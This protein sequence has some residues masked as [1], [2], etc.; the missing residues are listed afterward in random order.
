VIGGTAQGFLGEYMAGGVLALLGIGVETHPAS[1]IGTGMC[2]GIIYIRGTVKEHQLGKEVGVAELDGNDRRILHGLIVEYCN[3]FSYDAD[4][5][6]K[7]PFIKLY[8]KF[9][10]PYGKLYTT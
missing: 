6:L 4:I 5:L 7:Q 1:Y 3:L 8:P 10:R 2:G 9:L